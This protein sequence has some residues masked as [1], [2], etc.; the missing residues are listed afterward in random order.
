MNHTEH[1]SIAAK[2]DA[3]IAKADTT[4]FTTF[5]R[6]AQIAGLTMKVVGLQDFARLGDTIRIQK[7]DFS[8][9]SAEIVALEDGVV[10]AQSFEPLYGVGVGARAQLIAEQQMIFPHAAWRG[11]ALDAFASALDGQA[12]PKGDI[13]YPLYAEAPKS[14]RRRLLG[15]R[16]A[17]GYRVLDTMLPLCCGQRM[18]VFAGSGVGK[19]V[20]LG[21]L[22]NAV[23]CDVIV[24]A[25]IG[26]RG[27]EV[28]GFIDQTLNEAGRARSTIFVSTSDQSP[29]AKLRAAFSA[30]ATA[31]KF[32]DDGL[33][34]LL[35]FDSLT[36]F[37]EAHR[38]AALAA[39]ETASL[40]GFPPSTF[41]A[42]ASLVERAGPGPETHPDGTPHESGDIT[43]VFSVLVAGSNT[44]EPVADMIRGILD[45]HIVLNRA[46]AERGRFPA[47]DVGR[48][49]SRSLPRAASAEE[50]AILM[51]ARAVLT[52][53]E[54][55][56]VMVRAGLYEAGTDPDIDR[57]I[58]I[59][60]KLDAFIGERIDAREEAAPDG[61]MRDVHGEAFARLSAILDLKESGKQG[62]DGKRAAG[63]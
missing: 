24:V 26:E 31:E 46:I 25:L 37:A 60:P 11:R 45:G 15:G 33:Q 27:R 48:S 39:G 63:K 9:I 49:V 3:V 6:V 44:D 41:R 17:T 16:L 52:R 36:R 14:T 19:S 57:A 59:W 62:A 18:G 5:G 10:I 56:E 8:A 4:Y 13:A 1:G 42:L 22:V 20:L 54:D 12:A 43:A 51:K 58:A 29:L 34:V 50:N 55:V 7:N 35:I 40:H 53:Y 32:R 21:N 47:I 23:D 30:M 61:A 38:E 2:V 28:R